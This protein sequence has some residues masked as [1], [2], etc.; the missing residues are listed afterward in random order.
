MRTLVHIL[1][2]AAIAVGAVALVNRT[3]QGKKLL[4]LAA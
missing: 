2:S 4:G 3:E 1:V